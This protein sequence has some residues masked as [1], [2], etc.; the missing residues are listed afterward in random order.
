MEQRKRYQ[1]AGNNLNEEPTS[2]HEKSIGRFIPHI[3]SNND[4]TE[5]RHTENAD[6]RK[7]G[8]RTLVF[9]A[10]VLLGIFDTLN[11]GLGIRYLLS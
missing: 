9:L 11:P 5:S 6:A 7:S 1:I 2:V 3:F 8:L 10:E 4:N